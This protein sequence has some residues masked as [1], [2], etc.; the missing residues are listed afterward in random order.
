MTYLFQFII[1]H[2]FLNRKKSLST[3][4]F[5]RFEHAGDDFMGKHSVG[6]HRYRYNAL[7]AQLS[8]TLL[9]LYRTELKREG[10][11]EGK[12]KEG[13]TLPQ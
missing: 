10:T 13:K 9:I 5:D 11:R 7:I 6:H 12:K 3:D 1:L 4:L 8:I 2:I